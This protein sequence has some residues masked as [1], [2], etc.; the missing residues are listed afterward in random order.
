MTKGTSI[1]VAILGACALAVLCSCGKSSAK[2][3]TV[4]TNGGSDTMVNLAQMWAEEY[5]VVAPN[6]SVEVSGGGS[7]VGMRD[8][9]QGII[10]I[11][12][13]SRDI[14]PREKEQAKK[15]TGKD[16]T[17]KTVGHDAIA[18]YINKDNPIETLTV[19]QLAAIFGEGGT[20][21]KWSQIGVDMAK[22]GGSDE[23]VRVSRQNSSGTYLYF[24]DHVLG[25]KD[26]K[27]GSRD[28]SGSKDVVELVARTKSAIGYSGMGYATKDVKMLTLKANDQAEPVSPSI[29]N[30]LNRSYPLARSLHI[31]TLGNPEGAVKDYI[32]WIFSP[33]G[34]HIVEK[35]GYVPVTAA[36]GK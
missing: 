11:A 4:I 28:M 35:A 7:G 27:P 18:V 31:Y 17:E 16:V 15:N 19:A 22:I 20:V 14:E 32:E 21:E 6:V 30:V 33:A 23:I 9:T 10:N 36:N 34:Q 25:K 26:F 5:Q 3:R 8:L 13:C 29:A 24:R 2:K 1:T 12:N